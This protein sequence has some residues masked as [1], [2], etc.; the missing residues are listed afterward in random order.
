MSCSI[1]SKSTSVPVENFK[2]L[3][4]S[5]SVI[6]AGYLRRIRSQKEKIM[7]HLIWYVL[8]GFLVG[9]VAKAI[10]HTHLLIM[11]TV[12][13][14]SVFSMIGGAVTHLFYPPS[15]RGKFHLGGLIVS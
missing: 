2:W 12:V 6:A 11:W 8:V 7:L 3:L 13:L 4:T 9:C 14:C 1:K 10:M 15:A 5:D